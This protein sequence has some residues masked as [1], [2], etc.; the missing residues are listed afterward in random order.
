[1]TPEELERERQYN[2]LLNSRAGISS[3]LVDDQ[4]DLTNALLDQVKNL[5][6]AKQQQ[7]E[8]RSLTRAISRSAQD[9]YAISQNQLGTEKNLTN[10]KKQQEELDKRAR[11]INRLK[12]QELSTS[13][14]LNYDI[15]ESLDEQY[16]LIIQQK[17][18][19]NEVVTASNKIANNIGVKTFSG[20]Q[21]IVKSIPGLKGLS[22][23]FDDAAQASLESAQQGEKSALAFAKGANAFIDSAGLAIS[24]GSI[25]NSFFALNKEQTEFRRLTG[26]TVAISDTLNDS[27]I[28]TIDYIAQASALTKQFGFNATVAFDAFNIQ[29]ASELEQLMGLAAEEAGNLA[30]FAQVNGEN[31]D[32]AG[33][34]LFAQIGQINKA[35]KS[36]VSQ[37]LIFQDIGNISKSIGLTFGGNLKLIGE[38]ALEARQLGINLAQVD[39]IAE[40]LLNIEQSIAAEFEAEVISG[41]QLNLEQARYFA[42]TNDL[43]GVTREIGKNQEV[44]NSFATGTRIEQEAIAGAIGL[45]RD[46]ISEMIFQQKLSAGIS[47]EEAARLAGMTKEDAMRLSLQESINKSLAKLTEVLAGPLDMLA[48]M[49]SSAGILYTTIGLIATVS[50]AKTIAGFAAMALQSGAIAASSIATA[51]A[52]TFGIGLVAI[53]AGMVAMANATKKAQNE[54]SN[55]GDAILPASGGPIVSTMEG[56]LF[57]GTRNDDV[58]IGPGLARGGR[59]QGLSKEDVSAIATAVRDGASSA[60]I[61]LDGGRVSNRIQPPLAMN[62][63]KYSV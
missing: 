20:L 48:Q 2:E 26:E 40:G 62:T 28:T 21:K 50:L 57:Q 59:N 11:N 17:Q 45:S 13:D 51:S 18:E 58:L 33:D 39:K 7:S 43:A 10:L 6:V 16:R 46:E 49:A 12:N 61:N 19:L 27:L 60:Q 22:K 23:P 31:L 34:E 8:I 38:A 36:A 63:R 41:K 25:L 5:D 15:K 14:T 47:Q 29:A 35:N 44:I 56:G 30:L 3:Q 42:L 1:M 37:K 4:Q 54:L 32:A 9:N 52:V 24:F 53:I 55:V